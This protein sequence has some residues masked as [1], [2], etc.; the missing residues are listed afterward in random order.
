MKSVLFI[1]TLFLS[2]SLF[3]QERQPIE[4]PQI[5][6]K[7]GLTQTVTIDGVSITFVEV[8][9]DSRCPINTNCVWAGEAKIVVSIAKDD[10]EAIEKTFVFKN[11][12]PLIAGV[13]N[14]KEL[15]LLRLSP[16]PDAAISEAD[17]APYALALRMVEK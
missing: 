7:V 15:Q 14:D 12:K 13:Y 3:A 10:N 17:K 16:Y 8:V 6:V 5:A 4:V 9:E 2:V 1:V 11:N